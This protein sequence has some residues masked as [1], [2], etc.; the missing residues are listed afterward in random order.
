MVRHAPPRRLASK[1]IEDSGAGCSV[2]RSCVGPRDRELP[3]TPYSPP[4][5]G[6]GTHGPAMTTTYVLELRR[7]GTVAMAWPPR[8]C[9]IAIVRPQGE[10]GGRRRQQEQGHS[11]RSLRSRNTR[12]SR[13]R[14]SVGAACSTRGTVAAADRV[15]VFGIEFDLE[16][17]HAPLL[18]VELYGQWDCPL[19]QVA[20]VARVGAAT[21][22]PGPFL[23][24]VGLC[25]L[26]RRQG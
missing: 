6:T 25:R 19:P 17:Q 7:M 3:T 23:H 5:H 20:A 2:H 10:G 16:Q 24:N 4:T 12:S 18:S 8:L 1:Y 11:H 22:T 15:I 9:S 14:L 13:T 26:L 21:Y